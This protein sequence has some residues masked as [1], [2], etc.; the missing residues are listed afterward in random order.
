VSAALPSRQRRTTGDRPYLRVAAHQQLPPPIVVATSAC[1]G[2][3]GPLAVSQ[4]HQRPPSR[5]DLLFS[6]LPLLSPQLRFRSSSTPC[7]PDLRCPSRRLAG[8]WVSPVPGVGTPQSWLLLPASLSCRAPRPPSL[9]VFSA[10][11]RR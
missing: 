2:G 6:S 7:S 5:R 8:P 4:P 3:G 1:G 9:A 11:G 10:D